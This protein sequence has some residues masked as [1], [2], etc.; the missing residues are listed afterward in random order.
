MGIAPDC[1]AFCGSEVFMIYGDHAALDEISVQEKLGSG[2]VD[3][4]H[5]VPEG[6]P[7]RNPSVTGRVQILPP[8]PSQRAF[9]RDPTNSTPQP[10]CNGLCW[11]F[12][13]EASLCS[14]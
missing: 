5:F 7:Q 11:R 6:S 13:A 9:L 12:P 8:Q 10:R 4:P 3:P 14:R 1:H 2:G